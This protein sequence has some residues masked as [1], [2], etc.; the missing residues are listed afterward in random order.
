MRKVY[1]S[2]GVWLAL[3]T[4]CGDDVFLMHEEYLVSARQ[5][6]RYL[7]GG[8]ES[9]GAGAV[10]TMFAGGVGLPGYEIVVEGVD[11]GAELTVRG[12]AGLVL[13]TR[14]YTRDFLLS[15]ERDEFVVMLSELGDE[16]RLS[17]WGGETCEPV[18]ELDPEP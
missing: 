14:S 2:A 5:A 15:G 17:Y 7:G 12:D 4:S 8:C 16:L 9:I 10:S 18:R 6:E 1:V 11:D 3:A 13:L